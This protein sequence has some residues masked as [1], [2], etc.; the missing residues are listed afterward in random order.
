[1]TFWFC[2]FPVSAALESHLQAAGLDAHRDEL[3]SLPSGALLLYPQPHELVGLPGGSSDPEQWLAGY[4][5]VL[6]H[7]SGH[8]LV[9][10]WRLQATAS[11]AI[12]GWINDGS[13]QA[14]GKPLAI[15]P[16]PA[17]I[18]REVLQSYPQL[19]EAY[20]DLELQAELLGGASDSD[21]IALLRLSSTPQSL[22]AELQ[23]AGSDRQKL[24]EQVKQ[25]QQ[26]ASV[27]LQ[28][29]YQTKEELQRVFLSAQ[30]QE[31][32]FTTQ[33]KKLRK[34]CDQL[35]E[36]LTVATSERDKLA[37]QAKDAQEEAELTLLQLHQVQEELEH[38][39]LTS[40][41]QEQMLNTQR[42][43]L[44]KTCDQLK[45]EL[46]AV[47]SERDKL[48]EELQQLSARSEEQEQ[49]LASKGGQLKQANQVCDQLKSELTAVTSE[50]DK[51]AEELQQS[52]EAGGLTLQQLSQV[53]SKMNHYFSLSR[54]Q[55]AVIDRQN[56]LS[57]QA[58]ELAAASV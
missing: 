19:L 45:S 50:R 5:T 48:A 17:V 2:P 10:S 53:Q 32:M 18:L 15:A 13:V 23:A 42:K 34:S 46:T 14:S 11:E 25:S 54:E 9:A 55:Q 4:S 35:Q 24:A 12:A 20:L 29:L 49:M 38:I 3:N 31:Q 6:H 41:E 30:E 37:E 7:A 40:Q 27:T 56:R 22:L 26:K 8:R 52:Q 47:T 44:R 21:Y 57:T 39:F 1:V 36:E 16:L 33:K 51:L 58:L 28:E 43:K